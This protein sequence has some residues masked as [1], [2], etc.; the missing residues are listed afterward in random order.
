MLLK[1]ASML[2]LSKICLVTYKAL[3]NNQPIFLKEMFTPPKRTRDLRSSDQNV[4]F[5]PRIKTE[6]GEG[7]FSVT[8]PKLWNHLPGEIKTSKTEKKS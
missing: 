4:L 7:F 6:K 3:C 2:F 1:H 8:A 5:V